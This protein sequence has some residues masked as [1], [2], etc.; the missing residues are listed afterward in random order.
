MKTLAALLLVV[1][2]SV[3]PF[4]CASEPDP[5]RVR[6]ETPGE[7]LKKLADEFG[8][9]GDQEA[10]VK[11]LRFLVERYPRSKCAEEAKV[12][13]G[14][15]GIDVEAEVSASASASARASASASASAKP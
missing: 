7:A 10:R 3:A 12:E 13:L 2:S 6:E 4:Q 5:N 11:T 8:E 15:L 9:A 1:S 14:E